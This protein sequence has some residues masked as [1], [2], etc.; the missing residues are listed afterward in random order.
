MLTGVVVVQKAYAEA[1]PDQVAAFMEAYHASVDFVNSD[2]E[3]AARLVGQ[4]DIIPEAVAV[5]ALP[6]CNIVLIDGEEMVS[7]LGG[8]LSELYAQNP[9]SVGGK[10]PEAD[11]YY[12]Q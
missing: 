10:L 5:K 7:K 8:Y 3:N 11:F 4:Y 9:A 2:L 6:A 1:H 12:V